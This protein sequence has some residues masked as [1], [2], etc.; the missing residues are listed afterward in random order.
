[1]PYWLTLH[2]DTATRC[3]TG[4][5]SKSTLFNALICCRREYES[6]DLR[7]ASKLTYE[8]HEPDQRIGSRGARAAAPAR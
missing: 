3:P 8:R 5:V 4:C 6:A 1:M 7:I 2:V